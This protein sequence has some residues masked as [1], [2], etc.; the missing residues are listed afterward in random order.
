MFIYIYIYI[1]YILCKI[2]KNLIMYYYM[3]RKKVFLL[4]LLTEIKYQLVFL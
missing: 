4:R 2:S 1:L 3:E